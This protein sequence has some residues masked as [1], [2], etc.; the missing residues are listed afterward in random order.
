MSDE[1][2]I[3]DFLHSE[4]QSKAFSTLMRKYQE[5]V[6]WVVRKMVFSHDD[7]DDI[8]QNVFIKVFKYL[9]TYKGEA[10]LYT[11]IYRIAI[12]ESINFLNKQKRKVEFTDEETLQKVLEGRVEEESSPESEEMEKL[13][14]LAIA[15]LPEKQRAVFI[16][17]Y[18][19]EMKYED[20]AKVLETSEGG[21]KANYHHAVKKIE[22]YIKKHIST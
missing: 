15:S 7:A 17:R 8:T 13:V 10:Q 5:R 20:M 9:S 1:D 3:R 21:L 18:Y 14:H 22:E 4:T 11:W 16:M 12:N 2:L 19:E 6:Y